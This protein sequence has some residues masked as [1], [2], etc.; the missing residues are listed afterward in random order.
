MVGL[1]AK[2]VKPLAN[3]FCCQLARTGVGVEK[4]TSINRMR[5]SE[6]M[7]VLFHAALDFDFWRP[8]DHDG[9]TRPL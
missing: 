8:A 9:A 2:Q 3:H 5:F 1:E 4:V 6:S 7:L